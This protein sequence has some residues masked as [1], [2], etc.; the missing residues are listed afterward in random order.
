[1][2]IG[3]S[4]VILFAALALLFLTHDEETKFWAIGA[5]GLLTGYWLR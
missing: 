4:V 2:S 3:V 5:L 1:M